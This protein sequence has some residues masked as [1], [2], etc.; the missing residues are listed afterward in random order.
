MKR[1]VDETTDDLT[2]SLLAAGIEHRPPPGNK[3]HVLVALG[4]GGAF[5]LFS[6]N[7]FA[8]LSTTAGK[9]TAAGVAVGVAGAV[10]VGVPYAQQARSGASAS[11]TRATAPLTASTDDVANE[12]APD[13]GGSIAASASAVRRRSSGYAGVP[14]EAAGDPAAGDP[15]DGVSPSSARRERRARKASA[16]KARV[17]KT[18]AASKASDVGEDGRAPAVEAASTLALDE[19][20]ALDSELRLVDDMHWAARR[21]DHEAL[22]RYLERYRAAFPE[23]Q[24]QKEV[25]EL[26]GRLDRSELAGAR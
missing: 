15:A 24:L 23:G 16:K 1:L 8:W 21:H 25:A 7:A 14:S 12:P 26:A 10:W 3:A 9:V 5:G 22:A 17:R 11:D 19:R 13:L 6:A 20:G 4:A 18:L 2:R